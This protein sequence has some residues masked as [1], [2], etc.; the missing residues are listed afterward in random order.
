MKTILF[1]IVFLALTFQVEAE[2]VFVNEKTGEVMVVPD[3]YKPAT[4]IHIEVRS[5]PGA[6]APIFERRVNRHDFFHSVEQ[7]VSNEVLVFQDGKFT[8]I[9]EHF[10]IMGEPRF[11]LYIPIIFF[12]IFC[13]SISNFGKVKG[14]VDLSVTLF[15]VAAVFVMLALLIDVAFY[16]IVSPPTLS[17]SILL[18]LVLIIMGLDCLTD[19]LTYW[20]F[21]TIFYGIAI[22]ALLSGWIL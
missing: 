13:M 11:L 7:H 15:L 16:T 1:V 10:E 9:Q 20:F 12:S 17:V 6:K 3:G 5:N 2:Q 4:S 14:K 8:K 18:V 21:T 19:S 22:L